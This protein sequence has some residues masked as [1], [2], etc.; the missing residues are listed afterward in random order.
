[1]DRSHMQTKRYTH[2]HTHTIKKIVFDSWYLHTSFGNSIL[3]PFLQYNKAFSIEEVK[4]EYLGKKIKTII[5]F[6]TIK[7]TLEWHTQQSKENLVKR[8]NCK[9]KRQVDQFVRLGN[10][11]S[12]SKFVNSIKALMSRA[13]QKKNKLN[14]MQTDNRC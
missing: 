12:Y 9:N 6:H 11:F 1:M 8:N 5:N 10:T 7:L 3:N 14:G 13:V 4:L 2:I